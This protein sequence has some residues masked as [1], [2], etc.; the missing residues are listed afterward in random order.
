MYESDLH[1]FK[2]ALS[3]S[4]IVIFQYLLVS[5]V[6]QVTKLPSATCCVC[7]VMEG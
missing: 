5:N 7:I 2:F 6:N 4:S 1:G 3:G